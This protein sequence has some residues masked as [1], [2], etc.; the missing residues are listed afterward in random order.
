[1]LSLERS[2]PRQ[3]GASEDR[4]MNKQGSPSPADLSRLSLG[5]LQHDMIEPAGGIGWLAGND[6]VCLTVVMIAWLWLIFTLVDFLS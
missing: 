6:H 1:M 3:V 2:C 5:D 4:H